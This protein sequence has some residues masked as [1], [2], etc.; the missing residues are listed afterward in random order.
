MNEAEKFLQEFLAKSQQAHNQVSSDSPQTQ[1]S[2]SCNHSTQFTTQPQY[3]GAATIGQQQK[4]SMG[5][6]FKR[7]W[8]N[9]SLMGRAS[10]SEYW[11]AMLANFI[12]ATLI[13]IIISLI[14]PIAPTLVEVI[15]SI[16]SLIVV[17][18]SIAISVRRLHDVG[19]S[20]W[21]YLLIL[22]PFIGG[23]ILLWFDSRPSQPY[24]NKYGPVPNVR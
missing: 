8:T 14:V 13:G 10:L 19:K 7:F 5:E 9:W 6:A 3:M 21:F 1:N 2:T 23:L 22:L 18:P 12:L 11:F 17:W 20:G 4:V 15:D 16:F 24:E